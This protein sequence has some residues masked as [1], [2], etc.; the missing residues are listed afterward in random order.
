MNARTGEVAKEK[1]AVFTVCNLAYLRKALVLAES[2]W[3]HRAVR[4]TVVLFDRNV[5]VVDVDTTATIRW[6][7]GMTLGNISPIAFERTAV[8]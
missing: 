5:P 2:V 8:A 4:M 7:E 6:S 3:K 1:Y